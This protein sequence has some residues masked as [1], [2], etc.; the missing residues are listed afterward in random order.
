MAH[1]RNGGPDAP[2]TLEGWDDARFAWL[3]TLMGGF[4]AAAAFALMWNAGRPGFS[5]DSSSQRCSARP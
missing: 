5:L 2:W 1:P 4:Y 3:A